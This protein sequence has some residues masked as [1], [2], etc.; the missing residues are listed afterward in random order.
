MV[1]RKIEIIYSEINLVAAY[2]GSWVFQA[3]TEAEALSLP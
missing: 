1:T 2:A 3:C